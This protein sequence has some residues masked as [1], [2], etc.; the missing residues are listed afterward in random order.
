MTPDRKITIGG[1]EYTLDGSFRT[2]KVIQSAFDK[3]ILLVLT[4]AL[5]FRLRFD[6]LARLFRIGI[7]GSGGTPPEIDAIEQAVV[8]DIGI[9]AAAEL[10]ME[11]LMAATSPKKEREGNVNG[12]LKAIEAEKAL[13]LKAAPRKSASRGGSTGSSAS[14]A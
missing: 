4:D 3:D 14:A 5:Q 9:N 8:E 7:E 12:L 11:W 1:Q 2:L 10:A 6:D 13:R